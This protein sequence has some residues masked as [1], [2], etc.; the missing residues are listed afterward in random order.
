ML[1]RPRSDAKR[2][3]ILAA[4]EEVFLREGYLGTNMD[5]IAELAQVSKPTVY[6]HF[7]NKEALFVGLVGEMTTAAGDQVPDSLPPA[8]TLDQLRDQL[9]AQAKAQLAVVLTPRILQIRRLVIGE[10]SRFPELARVLHDAGP[11]R[12]IRTFTDIFRIADADG[13]LNVPD[14]GVAARQFN[15]LVM[16][17]PVNS[18]MLLGDDAIPSRRKL[19][20][21]ARQAAELIVAGYRR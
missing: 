13:L 1:G 20:T 9:T 10:V 21:H 8:E 2:Q 17:D 12:A 3:A 16:G 11:Q 7:G 5:L 15:W 6:R 18:A 19:A 4:A 14:P